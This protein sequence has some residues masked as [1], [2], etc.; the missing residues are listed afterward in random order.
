MDC[1]VCATCLQ[2]PR[3]LKRAL[4]SIWEDPP[5]PVEGAEPKKKKDGKK[6]KK[7]GK[8]HGKKV[9]GGEGE[10]PK[11]LVP[12]QVIGE[13]GSS[14]SPGIFLSA[15]IALRCILFICMCSSSI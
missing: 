8:K 10:K 15:F 7:K 6:K 11:D 1:K 3:G 9:K 13:P 2:A 14:S 4:S 5:P 12:G